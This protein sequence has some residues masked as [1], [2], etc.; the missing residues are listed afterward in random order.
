MDNTE[1]STLICTLVTAN[2]LTVM[3]GVGVRLGVRVIV[4]VKVGVMVGVQVGT[5]KPVALGASVKVGFNSTGDGD[6][7]GLAD[8]AVGVQV[9][10]SRSGVLVRV[11]KTSTDGMV[12]CGNGFKLL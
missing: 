2:G 9:A 6:C 8:P 12:G 4:A 5:T 1:V 3:V 7:W 11:G 10:G